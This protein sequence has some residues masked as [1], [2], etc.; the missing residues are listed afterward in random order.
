MF[1]SSPSYG[2]YGFFGFNVF[3]ADLNGDGHPDLLF[4]SEY[5]PPVAVYGLN[6]PS[7]WPET[8]NICQVVAGGNCEM[9]PGLGFYLY[10]TGASG[11]VGTY[12]FVGNMVAYDVNGDGRLD[13]LLTNDSSPVVNGVTRTGAGALFVMYQPAGGWPNAMQYS[14]FNWNGKD[15]FQIYGPE[16]GSTCG[17]NSY[18]PKMTPFI[19]NV[20]PLE[21]TPDII[22]SCPGDGFNSNGSIYI[23]YE[24]KPFGGWPA[25]IDLNELN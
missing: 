7:R 25:A 13:L 3:V 8:Y 6:P 17:Y 20:S 2:G 18:A 5:Y 16:A 22:I 19:A 14:T 9:T 1:Y 24:N 11:W 15:S 21:P 23:L 10:G 12:G 4:S